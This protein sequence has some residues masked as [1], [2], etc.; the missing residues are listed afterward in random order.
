MAISTANGLDLERRAGNIGLLMLMAAFLASG[1]IDL[2]SALKGIGVALTLNAA[3]FAAGIAP[4]AYQGALT[5][6]LQDKNVAGLYYG[7]AALLITAT[8]SRQWLRIAVLVAGGLAV[9]AT[10][11]RTSMA[12]YAC[13]LLWLLVTPRLSLLFRAL[14][15]V[16]IALLFVWAEAN[17]STAGVYGVERAGS[18]ALRERILQASFDRV[19]L[20]PWSG[21]G[22]GTA[23]ADVDGVTWFFHNSYLALLAEG[24][25]VLFV[26]V[27]AVYAVAGFGLLPRRPGTHGRH[28]VGAATVVVLLCATQLGE[29]FFAPMSF[30]VVGAGLAL[31][32]EREPA[33]PAHPGPAH[34][35]L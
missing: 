22:L 9:V 32:A 28:V 26:G 11:S 19:A 33:E 14:T 3:L 2:A 5:G 20:A 10:D 18:D 29:V 12:A 15:G 6:Y 4:D 8:T 16:G 24:G 27:L 30:V 31:L 17:L 25:V 7:V 23:T 21:G 34:P 13:G 35:E 1:R